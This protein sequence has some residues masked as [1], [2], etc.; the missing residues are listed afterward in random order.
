MNTITHS[1]NQYKTLHLRFLSK[2]LEW[3]LEFEMSPFLPTN[4]IS[5]GYNKKALYEFMGYVEKQYGMIFYKTS[6]HLKL[7]LNKNIF[8]SFSIE[9]ISPPWLR[10]INLTPGEAPGDKLVTLYSREIVSC[11]RQGGNLEMLQ[12]KTDKNNLEFKILHPRMN[13]VVRAKMH[14]IRAYI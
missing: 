8:F 6:F 13:M 1:Y 12:T 10:Q 5:F 2:T 3:L 4:F 11:C 14:P 9:R 7:T